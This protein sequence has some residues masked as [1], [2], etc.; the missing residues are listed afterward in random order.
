V[1]SYSAGMVARLAFAVATSF[2]PD[3]LLM[4]EWINAADQAF[5]HKARNHLQTYFA[6]AKAAVLAT[7]DHGIIR[8]LCNKVLVLENGVLKAFGC[9]KELLAA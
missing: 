7:H 3:I 5:V 1:K 6:Q 8:Q 9:P 2:E 4:D